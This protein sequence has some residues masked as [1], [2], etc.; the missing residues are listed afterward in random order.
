MAAGKA[1]RAPE[2][3]RG[4]RPGGRIAWIGSEVWAFLLLHGI[5]RKTNWAASI[6]A[7]HF[8]SRIETR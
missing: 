1:E 2:R 6:G 3:V 8:D 4:D 7:A 5:S